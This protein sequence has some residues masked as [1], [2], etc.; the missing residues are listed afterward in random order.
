[1]S[2]WAAKVLADVPQTTTHGYPG[3][4]IEYDD[5]LAA[6]A[7]MG[8][9]DGLMERL[10]AYSSMDD[11]LSHRLDTERRAAAHIAA[12]TAKIEE[13]RG[14]R[15]DDALELLAAHGQAQEAYAAQLAAEARISEL[16][17]E[18]NQLEVMARDYAEE[19]AALRAKVARLDGALRHYRETLCEGFCGEDMWADEGH[20]HPEIQR[21]CGGCL[22]ASVLLSAALTDGGKDG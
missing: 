3:A 15:R 11:H 14:V 19:A 21:D 17:E 10:L 6:I 4:T 22:A 13:L 2:D 8:A 12:L 9:G 18:C 5:A 1:M 7:R 16:V 20:S